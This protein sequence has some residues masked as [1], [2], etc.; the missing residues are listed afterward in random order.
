MLVRHD[1]VQPPLSPLYDGRYLVLERSLHF[2]KLQMGTQTDTVSTHRLKACHATTDAEAAL[3]PAH[4]RPRA[5]RADPERS[6]GSKNLPDGLPAFQVP[7]RSGGLKISPDSVPTVKVPW[8]GRSKGHLIPT[9]APGIGSNSTD[10]LPAVRAPERSGG[11]QNLPDG[12]PAVQ[13]P[14]ISPACAAANPVKGRA[15]A[16]LPA[17]IAGPSAVSGHQSTPALRG[18]LPPLGGDPIP[19]S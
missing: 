12:V 10:G 18:V 8:E 11:L 5:A 1:G 13:A 14:R 9:E 2:S 7:G 4:G 16:T 19:G 17:H 3:P 6:E 15:H